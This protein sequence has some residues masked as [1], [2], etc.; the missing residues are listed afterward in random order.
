MSHFDVL[1]QRII[2]QKEPLNNLRLKVSAVVKFE[3]F[4][5]YVSSVQ[6]CVLNRHN[7]NKI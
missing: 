5:S 3:D 2:Q 4:E 7:Q 1:K 6:S